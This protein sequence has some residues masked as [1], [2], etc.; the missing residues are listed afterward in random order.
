[1]ISTTKSSFMHMMEL[2]ELLKERTKKKKRTFL[3]LPFCPLLV[4]LFWTD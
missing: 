3:L 1:M 2:S 4:R